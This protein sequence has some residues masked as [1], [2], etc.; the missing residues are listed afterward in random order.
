MQASAVM[1]DRPDSALILL[2]SIPAPEGMNDADY[3]YYCLLLTEA[4][5][6]TYYPFTSR[7]NTISGEVQN[8]DAPD[9]PETYKSFKDSIDRQTDREQSLRIQNLHNMQKISREKDALKKSDERKKQWII[10]LSFLSLLSFL[11]AVIGVLHYGKRRKDELLVRERQA[12]FKEE[13]YER[14]LEQLKENSEL[15]DSL[16]TQLKNNAAGLDPTEKDLLEKRVKLLQHENKSIELTEKSRELQHGRFI[17]SPIYHR[18]KK[19]TPQ[20]SIKDETLEELKTTINEIYIDFDEKL[21]GRHPKL[22]KIERIV[23]YLIKGKFTISEIALLIPL[24]KS[25]VS[26]CRSRLF[27]KIHG[28]PGTGEDLDRFIDGL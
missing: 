12:R 18:L 26:K 9:Y 24:S 27:K 22:S 4:L 8:Q 13:Q 10:G 3:A 16:K 7:T 2:E 21:V 25:G 23:C 14:S 20:K 19:A 1:N 17:S 6:K 5:D 15:I 11:F 28:I